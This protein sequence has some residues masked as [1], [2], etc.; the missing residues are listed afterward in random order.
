MNV[1]VQLLHDLV[2]TASVSGDEGLA[3]ALLVAHMNQSGFDAHVDEVGNAV[4]LRRGA[5]VAGGERRTLV[6]LGHIDTVPGEIP[7][8]IEDG[9][10]HGRGSVDAKGP[11]ATFTRAVARLTPAAG[12]DLVVIGAVEEEVASSKGAR[13]IAQQLSAPEACIIGEPSDWE[14][15]TLGYKGCLRLGLE[16]EAPV[17]HSAG[18]EPPVA[19]AAADVWQAL[20]GW[21]AEYNEQR[22][23]LFDQVLPSLQQFV[24]STDGLLER[25]EVRVGFR[26]PPAFEVG[27]LEELL[28]RVAPMARREF[29][30]HEVAWS[31]PRTSLLARSLRR[32]ILKAGGRGA[33][34]RKTGTSDMNVLGPVW[35]CPLVAYGPG[36]S[37]LDHRPDERLV[38]ADYEKAI[39]VLC[40]A[41]REG[42]WAE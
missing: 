9:V 25:V 8:R 26:L 31:S 42:G 23:A 22:P 30:G 39:E 28:A 4:G 11:L 35:G 41:L 18:P 14:A 17:G 29:H 27:V 37:A 10:L 24:T 36:D 16:F 40:G 33:F 15:V 2:S 5:E 6:L 32:A 3:S 19:E 20:K 21:C 12:V 38:L 1:D 34:K 13:H 7:V